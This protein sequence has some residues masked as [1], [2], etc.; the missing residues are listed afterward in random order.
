MHN[1]SLEGSKFSGRAASTDWYLAKLAQRQWRWSNGRTVHKRRP[2]EKVKNTTHVVRILNRARSDGQHFGA[3]TAPLKAL[4]QTKH[5]LEEHEAMTL[6]A[7]FALMAPHHAA[8]FT[9][10]T[11]RHL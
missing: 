9:P 10:A 3:S 4:R 2:T 1:L 7:C 6:P 11:S 8:P 5:R